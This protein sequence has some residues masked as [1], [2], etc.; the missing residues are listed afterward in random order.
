V[1]KLAMGSRTR[2]GP[3]TMST[4]SMPPSMRISSWMR[5]H[6][7]VAFIGTN[8]IYWNKRRHR[9]LI[10]GFSNRSVMIRGCH[11]KR[12]IR[13]FMQYHRIGGH[14]V[15]H[16]LPWMLRMVHYWRV[17]WCTICRRKTPLGPISIVCL[18]VL[19][20]ISMAVKLEC[21]ARSLKYVPIFLSN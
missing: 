10:S 17:G 4:N 21:A 9:V 1:T 3:S 18:L 12:L 13:I 15:K 6:W 14:R 8:F 16:R 11:S 2:R 5:R 7:P 19:V 20:E